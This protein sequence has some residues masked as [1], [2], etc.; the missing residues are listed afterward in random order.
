[1]DVPFLH[2]PIVT[3]RDY[4]K[5]W[6]GLGFWIDLTIGNMLLISCLPTDGNAMQM[7]VQVY[8]PEIIGKLDAL[9]GNRLNSDG[10][11]VGWENSRKIHLFDAF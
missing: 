5:Y 1:M 2:Q 9:S 11:P 7:D 4:S 3:S 6:S 10:E 8:L